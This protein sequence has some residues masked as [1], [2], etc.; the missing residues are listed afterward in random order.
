MQYIKN[1]FYLFNFLCCII[2]YIMSLKQLKRDL[3]IDDYLTAPNT[4]PKKYNTVK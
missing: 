1:Y 3:G 4:K 2:I